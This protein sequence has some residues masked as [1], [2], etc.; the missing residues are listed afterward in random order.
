[1]KA[2]KIE[3]APSLTD[4]T[5]FGMNIDSSSDQF[6]SK[7][8]NS[9]PRLLEDRG[10]SKLYVTGTQKGYYFLVSSKNKLIYFNKYIDINKGLVGKPTVT[11]IAVWRAMGGPLSSIGV[12][13]STI[14]RYML[15]RFKI[16]MSDRIQT[17][18]GRRLWLDLM[19][20]ALD[21]DYHVA[22]VDFQMRKVLSLE[23]LTEL[24]IWDQM[25][26]G[27]WSWNSNKHQGL[28]FLISKDPLPKST[29]MLKDILENL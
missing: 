29:P 18:D 25:K 9:K 4:S 11:Q 17:L 23:S 28:R 2:P 3:A 22:L 14:F 19:G 13:K 10:S 26:D 27:A 16:L 5:D 20:T 12:V 15:P 21:E 6:L 24:R 7:L 8:M 1:M